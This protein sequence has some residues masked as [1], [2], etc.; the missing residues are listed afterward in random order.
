MIWLFIVVIVTLVVA[1]AVTLLFDS[2]SKLH[3]PKEALYI[4]DGAHEKIETVHI[5]SSDISVGIVCIGDK[6]ASDVNTL[7]E[8]KIKYFKHLNMSVYVL[9]DHMRFSGE[10]KKQHPSKSKITLAY[11]MLENLDSERI[12]IVDADIG[13]VNREIDVKEFLS[14]EDI[15]LQ[16]TQ[17]VAGYTVFQ[18]SII[19]LKK[20]KEIMNMLKSVWYDSTVSTR[21]YPGMNKV[22]FG[23]QT[24][25]QTAIE[26]GNFDI[27]Y[28]E[29]S[30]Q[31]CCLNA[32][33][34]DK[35]HLFVHFIGSRHVD[36]LDRIYTSFKEKQTSN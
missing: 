30:P 25:L 16:K 15:Q 27:T 22:D 1:S 13:I 9:R 28:K 31:I 32:R 11:W 2:E 24:S 3:I 10:S 21:R 8:D 23:E 7:M 35:G 29:L 20:S 12:M 26:G 34:C 18:S 6:Y 36:K 33:K 14:E 4:E 17:Y 19:I 5:G